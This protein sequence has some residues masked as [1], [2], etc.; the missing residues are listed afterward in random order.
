MSG[1][2]YL[3]HE[4]QQ[5]RNHLREDLDY[6]D[7]ALVRDGYNDAGQLLA[8]PLGGGFQLTVPAK[9]EQRFRVV[10]QGKK[11]TALFHRG[12]FS[13]ADGKG[14]FEGWSNGELWNG[15]EIPRFEFAVCQEILKALGDQQARF[16]GKAD[17]FVTMMDEEDEVWAGEEITIS[18]GSRIKGYGLGAGSWTWEEA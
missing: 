11:G 2:A 3:H 13:L 6:P 4:I 10:E 14:P 7:G 16:D 12:R 15:W 5:G 9:E 17:A 18:D 1:H 8:H